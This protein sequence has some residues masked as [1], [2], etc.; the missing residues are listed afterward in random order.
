MQDAT[1]CALSHYYSVLGGVANGL[2]L[3][4][5]PCHPSGSTGGAVVSPVSEDNPRLSNTVNL[6][7]VL[8]IELDHTLDELC[9][10]CVEIAQLWAEHTERCHLADGSP[11]LV[12]TQ[13]PYRL[14]RRRRHVY[15][16]PDCRTRINLGP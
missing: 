5:Y 2:D 12:E 9:R 3:R 11:A 14:P 1:W 8:N 15:G 13:H 7:A 10:A 6:A 4:Y 16:N